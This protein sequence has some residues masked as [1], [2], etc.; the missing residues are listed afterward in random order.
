[1]KELVLTIAMLMI[2]FL[3]A[4][5]TGDGTFFVAVVIFT[6]LTIVATIAEYRHGGN[7]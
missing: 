5:W 6:L 1:M 2:S 3:V 4:L 7:K